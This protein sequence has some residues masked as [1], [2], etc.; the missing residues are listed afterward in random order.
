MNEFRSVLQLGM[1]RELLLHEIPA[2][3]NDEKEREAPAKRHVLDGLD[4]MVSYCFE[5]FAARCVGVGEVRG[6]GV[7]KCGGGGGE[8]WE[9]R[10][11]GGQSL[12]PRDFY[13]NSVSNVG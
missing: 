9:L 13:D 4:V 12:E 5:L 11:V 2:V 3:E 7:E 1:S 8:W 6:Y 10:Q